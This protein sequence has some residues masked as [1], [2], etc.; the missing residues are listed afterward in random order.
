MWH[1]EEV[2]ALGVRCYLSSCKYNF[3]D[4]SLQRFWLGWCTILLVLLVLM[5]VFFVSPCC[6]PARITDFIW[7]KCDQNFTIAAALRAKSLG[8]APPTSRRGPLER[9]L[10]KCAAPK[11]RSERVRPQLPTKDS[12]FSS[13]S[14]EKDF[15]GVALASG[16]HLLPLTMASSSD[17]PSAV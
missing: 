4:D 1:T 5:Q 11:S 9:S 15:D 6:P 2:Y 14:S 3:T 17:H 16:K 13:I 10:R 7:A 8:I 12:S